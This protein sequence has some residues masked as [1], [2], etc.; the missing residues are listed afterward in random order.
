MRGSMFNIE[1]KTLIAAPLI[2][3]AIHAKA[4]DLPEHLEIIPLKHPT[5]AAIDIKDLPELGRPEH[6]ILTLQRQASE[7]ST[8]Q[9]IKIADARGH[10]TAFNVCIPED[11]LE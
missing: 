11:N 3:F 7:G 9:E 4:F 10:Y 6:C 2:L 8:C 5:D 1:F